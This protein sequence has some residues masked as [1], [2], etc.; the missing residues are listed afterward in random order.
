MSLKKRHW[1]GLLAMAVVATLMPST[2]VASNPAVTAV[3][4][5]LDSPRGI[6]FFHGKLVV[7]EAGHGGSDCFAPPGAP[8][9]FSLCVG[10]TG[11]VSLVNASNGTHTP[12]VSGLF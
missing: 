3:T 8:P 1:F 7:G 10:A 6:A 4:S 12:L 9:G 11:Q 2:A 5:G